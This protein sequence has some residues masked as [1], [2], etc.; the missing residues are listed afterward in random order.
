MSFISEQSKLQFR[1]EGFNAFSHANFNKPNA[2]LSS[3]SFG[4]VTGAQPSRTLQLGL[5]FVF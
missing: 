1:F 3:T 2:N 5:K 4:I